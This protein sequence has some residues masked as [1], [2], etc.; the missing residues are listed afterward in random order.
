MFG[1]LGG[2]FRFVFF[3]MVVALL[4]GAAYYFLKVNPGRAP[5]KEGSPRSRKRSEP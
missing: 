5:W 1:C 3:F 4:G 2:L